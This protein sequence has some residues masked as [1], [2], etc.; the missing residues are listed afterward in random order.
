MDN[1]LYDY[2]ALPRRPRFE[3]ANGARVAFWVGLNVEHY[4]FGQPALSLAPFTAELV[5][6]PLNYGW[7]D[8]GNRAGVWRLARIFEQAG[9]R[10]T[11]ILNSEVC[12]LYPEVVEEGVRLGWGWVAHGRNNSTWQVGMEEDDERS[13]IAEIADTIEKATGTRPRGWLGPALTSTM[14]TTNLLA[15]L[16]FTHTL[17]WANDDQ[18]YDMNVREGRLISVPYASEVNDIPLLHLRHFTGEQFRQA[19]IDQFDMLYEEG[20]ESARV[21]GIGVHPFLVGQPFR[22]RYLAEA[23]EHVTSHDD[24]WLTTSDEIADWHANAGARER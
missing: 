3:L 24:V 20:A 5:P 15:E 23:L 4:T 1:P 2:S 18:P 11:A 9:V 6:D 22:A 19:V 12:E 8:Y 10:P 14:N 13:Y 17:D 21:M 7:R 16:G